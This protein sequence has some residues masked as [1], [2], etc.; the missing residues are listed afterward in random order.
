[1]S[2]TLY[3]CFVL[4]LATGYLKCIV[5]LKD[6]AYKNEPDWDHPDDK[7]ASVPPFPLLWLQRCSFLS[8]AH[9][10]MWASVISSS[11]DFPPECL[12][13][14]PPHPSVPSLSCQGFTWKIC[15]S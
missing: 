14:F 12:R 7:T 15:K 5:T 9:G 13:G 1:M 11:Q 8:L 10:S 6:E 4:W 2:L 3:L